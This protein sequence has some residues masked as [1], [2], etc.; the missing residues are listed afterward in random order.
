MSKDV[1]SLELLIHDS[2]DMRETAVTAKTATVVVPA[3]KEDVFAYLANI[4]NLPH[5]ATEFCEELKVV[6]G[7]HK[8]VTDTPE[9]KVELLIHYEADPETGVIDMYSGPTED[10]Q[11]LFPTRVVGLPDGRSTFIFTMF[12][13]PEDSDEWFEAQYESLQR[14]LKNIE[15]TF[16]NGAGGGHERTDT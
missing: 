11:A 16:S 6:D 4:D 2:S 3:P 5:W 13:G 9:G 1:E 12:Q 14:E 8:V 7:H 15:R 10:Q